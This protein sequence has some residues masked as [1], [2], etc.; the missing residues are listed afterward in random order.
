MGWS[1]GPT[2]KRELVLDAVP[3]AVRTR[4]PKGTIIHSGQGCQ[5]GSDDWQRFCMLA[6]KPLRPE[7]EVAE[8]VSTKRGEL[9]MGFY[10]VP[11]REQGRNL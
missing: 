8:N 10:A 5:Y 4:R 1:T 9:Q 6:Q 3:K 2:L 7:P 11:T